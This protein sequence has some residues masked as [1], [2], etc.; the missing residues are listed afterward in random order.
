MKKCTCPQMKD[1]TVGTKK[2]PEA[3]SEREHIHLA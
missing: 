3:L 1:R 2:K